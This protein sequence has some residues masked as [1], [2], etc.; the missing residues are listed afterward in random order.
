MASS[1][2]PP[3]ELEDFFAPDVDA[4]AQQTF[5]DADLLAF[6]RFDEAMA[7]AKRH[8]PNRLKLQ[9]PNRHKRVTDR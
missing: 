8:T 1:E 4:R 5:L 7:A 3:P 2:G 9:S 6:T